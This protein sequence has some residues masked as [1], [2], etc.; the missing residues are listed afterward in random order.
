MKIIDVDNNEATQYLHEK[1]DIVI[2]NGY[3]S[4]EDIGIILD[5]LA[6]S[7]SDE[8]RQRN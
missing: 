7:C 4:L 6:T 5:N 1:L 2:E 3:I 8:E